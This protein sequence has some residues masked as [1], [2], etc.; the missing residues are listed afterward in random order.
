MVTG[1]LWLYEHRPAGSYLQRNDLA[2]D[3]GIGLQMEA[4]TQLR[5]L[6]KRRTAVPGD[7]WFMQ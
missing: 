3:S 5:L 6:V 1:E 4:T 2:D 7:A